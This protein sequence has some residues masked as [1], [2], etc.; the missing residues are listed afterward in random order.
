MSAQGLYARQDVGHGRI[1]PSCN[2]LQDAVQNTTASSRCAPVPAVRP[3]CAAGQGT[4]D[5]A[6][7]ERMVMASGDAQKVWFPAMIAM[8]RKA[9]DPAMSVDAVLV[10][11]DRLDATLQHIRSTRQILP[12][13]MWCPHCQAHH[14]AAPPRVSVRAT[15]LALGRFA[16]LAPTDV[17]ALE[18]RWNRYRRQ[19]QLD[20]YGQQEDA[21]SAPPAHASAHAR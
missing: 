3:P 1:L 12:A 2:V 13:M 7:R 8:L 16:D 18:K 20:R 17:Q 6:T 10:L 19:H 4:E 14:R 21:V 11:R 5:A 9:A 15:L